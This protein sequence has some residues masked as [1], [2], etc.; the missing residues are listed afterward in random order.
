[1]ISYRVARISPEQLVELN[2]VMEASR[3]AM[4]NVKPQPTPANI[5]ILIIA[6]NANIQTITTILSNFG[7]G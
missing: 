7:E 2:A 3:Q 1:M 6:V 4:Q 5:S